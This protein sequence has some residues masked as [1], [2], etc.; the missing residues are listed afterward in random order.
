MPPL[1]PRSMPPPPPPKFNSTTAGNLHEK[2]SVADKVK[3]DNVSVLYVL[4]VSDTMVKL[5]EYG[6][7]DDEFEEICD[8]T[9][10]R[11]SNIVTVQKPLWAL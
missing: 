11:N 3:P 2:R 10:N 5:M 6:D 7:D 4:V 1:P 9:F 8:E